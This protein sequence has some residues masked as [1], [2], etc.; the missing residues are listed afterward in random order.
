M[1]RQEGFNKPTMHGGLNGWFVTH[2]AQNRF[3]QYFT[4]IS[5]PNSPFRNR[6]AGAKEPKSAFKQR[7]TLDLK[8]LTPE[9]QRAAAFSWL[10]AAGTPRPG[11]RPCSPK[12]AGRAFR[13]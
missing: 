13:I 6:D 10:F 9:Q 4:D 2:K 12:G 5:D 7:T 1:L 3:A 8:P 11:R